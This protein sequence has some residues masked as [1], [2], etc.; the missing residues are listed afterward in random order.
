MPNALTFDAA[1]HAQPR[2]PTDQEAD[3]MAQAARRAYVRVLG[4]WT[5]DLLELRRTNIARATWTIEPA[6]TAWPMVA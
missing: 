1:D 2:I 5:S 3:A 4:A 6:M